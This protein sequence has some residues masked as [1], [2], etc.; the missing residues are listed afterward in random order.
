MPVQDALYTIREFE[1]LPEGFPAQL[2]DG[3]LVKEPPVRYSHQSLAA[4]IR[5]Q[6]FQVVDPRRVPDHPSTVKIDDHNAYN[7]DIVVI[8]APLAP[9]ALYMG[10]PQLA[11]E[12][13]SARTMKRDRH[14]K[15]PR[16]IELGV[17]EVWLVDEANETIEIH[18]RDG[19]RV[20]RAGDEARS[21]ILDGFVLVPATLFASPA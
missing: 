2:I 9:D 5:A 11:I 10:V 13:L 16:L 1:M 7:P 4:V 21:A 3:C 15:T 8:E 20:I 18:T 14:V 6:L 17:G 19:H 12:I